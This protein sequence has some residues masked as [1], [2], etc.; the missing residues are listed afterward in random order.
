MWKKNPVENETTPQA[1]P[2]VAPPPSAPA[3]KRMAPSASAAQGMATIGASITIRGDI[4]GKED[5]RIE[6]EVEGEIKLND[7]AVT[8]APGG[9]VKADI[10]G[11]SIRVEG[12][13]HGNLFGDNEVVIRRTGRVLGNLTAPRVTLEDGASFRGSIDM[14]SSSL[15]AS[16][17][18]A[19]PRSTGKPQEKEEP[20]E[21]AAVKSG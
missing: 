4:S 14:D 11:K 12:E 16:T 3:A 7:H 21:K 9:R 6:G 13:V 18:T 20:R 2:V 15:K 17:A 19:G 1:T 8:V 5:L 10:W